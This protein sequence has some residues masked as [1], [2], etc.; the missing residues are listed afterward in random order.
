MSKA[1]IEM[2]TKVT[3]V[4][5]APHGVRVNAVCPGVIVTELHR[6]A[7][8]NATDYAAFLE[9]CEATH[10]LGRAGTADEVAALVVFLASDDAAFITGASHSIDGGRALTSLR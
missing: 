8:M 3:A 1:A 4:E 2:M 9:R 7:G 6:S 10:P 5:L